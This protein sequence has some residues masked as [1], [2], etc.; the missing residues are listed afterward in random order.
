MPRKLQHEMRRRTESGK[1]ERL[2]VH[3]PRESQRPPPDRART[4]ERRRIGVRQPGRDGVRE[5]S[6]RLDVLRVP[7]VL[8]AARGP[9][10]RA[11]VLAPGET[12]G[13]AAA[14][15][16]DPR[17]THPIANAHSS[18][19]RC[20]ALDDADHLMPRDDRIPRRR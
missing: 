9:E 5:R 18:D 16:V 1:A 8:V 7:A 19:V 10:V 20:G 12:P 14:R 6:R 13:A 11:Q 3:Q 4:Q 2:A 15:M 17:Y